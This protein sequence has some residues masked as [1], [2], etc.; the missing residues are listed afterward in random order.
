M[1]NLTLMFGAGELPCRLPRAPRAL[2][3]LSRSGQ[4]TSP[5]PLLNLS[6]LQLWTRH[7][8]AHCGPRDGPCLRNRGTRC[9]MAGM[10][11]PAGTHRPRRLTP[12]VRAIQTQ[13]WPRTCTDVSRRCSSIRQVSP[14]LPPRAAFQ[15]ASP[16]RAPPT[17]QPGSLRSRVASGR[18]TVPSSRDGQVNVGRGAAEGKT[19]EGARM[20]ANYFGTKPQKVEYS[21]STKIRCESCFLFRAPPSARPGKEGHV[22]RGHSSRREEYRAMEDQEAHQE[23]R[24]GS[25]V[26]PNPRPSV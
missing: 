4:F 23:P 13:D 10:P 21:R 22:R 14:R 25:R 7:C 20:L 19:L 1:V 12:Q 5:A 24:F 3:T 9:V 8:C 11:S 16:P 2:G 26:R 18:A 17:L 6:R 15:G